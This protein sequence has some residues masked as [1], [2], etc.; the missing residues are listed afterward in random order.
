MIEPFTDADMDWLAASP[1]S[2][3][4]TTQRW[5]ATMAVERD[6]CVETLERVMERLADAADLAAVALAQ[7]EDI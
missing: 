7:L 5:L 4:D 2:D 6:R 1:G 3:S